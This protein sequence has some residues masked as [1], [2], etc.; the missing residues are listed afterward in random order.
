M[1]AFAFQLAWLVGAFHGGY[2][3]LP[4]W[5]DVKNVREGYARLTV[6]SI[7]TAPVDKSARAV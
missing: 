4:G 2:S 6:M 3:S 5:P 1:C 7:Q